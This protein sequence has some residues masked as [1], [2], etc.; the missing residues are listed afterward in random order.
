MN[1]L[2]S[3][4]TRAEAKSKGDYSMHAKDTSP[5]G[6]PQHCACGNTPLECAIE[7][8]TGVQNALVTDPRASPDCCLWIAHKESI[9]LHKARGMAV[10][11]CAMY[12]EI[13]PAL[14][15]DYSGHIAASHCIANAIVTLEHFISASERRHRRAAALLRRKY[16]K[17]YG[18]NAYPPRGDELELRKAVERLRWAG[19]KLAPPPPPPPNAWGV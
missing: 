1:G 7:T 19:S 10:M 2:G 18:K 3:G 13:L 6:A 5:V 11:T 15:D 14:R 17:E 16:G 4:Q 9:E 12:R 8:L